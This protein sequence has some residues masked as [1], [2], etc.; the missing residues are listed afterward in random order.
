MAID[1]TNFSNIGSEL[2]SEENIQPW[3][4]EGLSEDPTINFPAPTSLPG[5]EVR[6]N[7]I[8]SP[9]FPNM[10]VIPKQHSAVDYVLTS[11]R[12]LDSD[13]K[14]NNYG[15]IYTF[16]SGPDGSSFYDRYRAFG[17]EKFAEVGFSPFRNNEA[18]FNANTT[19]WDR[20]KRML[21]HSLPTLFKRGFIDGPKSLALMISGN[22]RGADLEDAEEYE[23]AAAIGMDSTGGIGAFM[24]NTVMNFGYTAGIISEAILEEIGMTMVTGLTRGSTAGAQAARTGML[25]NRIGKG[26]GKFGSGAKAMKNLFK[27]AKSPASAQKFWKAVRSPVG[28][29]VNPL[30]NTFETIRG[31]SKASKSGADLTRLA[32][33]SKTAG[34]LY[35]DVRNINMAVSEARLEA[36]M[37]ENDVYKELNAKYMKEHDGQAPDE[38]TQKDMRLQAKK[39]GLET[40]NGNAGF[41]YL[42]NKITFGNITSPKGGLRNFL[43]ETRK[44]IFDVGNQTGK[45]G[46]L[47]RVVYDKGK[48]AFQFEK[49]NAINLAKSWWKQ[50]GYATAKKTLGYFKSNVSEGL[51]ENIQ[52]IISRAN[53]KHYVEAYGTE[54]VSAALYGRGVMAQDFAAGSTGK[55]PWDTYMEEAEKEFSTT[56]FET[57]M[58]GFMMGTLSGPLNAAYPFLSTQY[59]RMYNKDEY[60][61]WKEMKLK[62]TTDIVNRLNEISDP[63]QGNIKSMLDSHIVNMGTQDA[64]STIQRYGTK[65]EALDASDESFIKSVHTMRESNSTEVFIDMLDSMKELTDQELADAVGSIEVKDAPKYRERIDR[66]INK[67]NQIEE[68]FKDAEKRFPNPVD[69]SQAKQDA[70]TPEEFK[71]QKALHDAWNLSV[72]NYVF[73][74]QSFKDAQQ[75]MNSINQEYLKDETLSNLDY[76]AAKVL[77]DPQM[78]RQQAAILAKELEA[79]QELESQFPGEKEQKIASIKRQQKALEEFIMGYAEFDVFYN[80]DT[81]AGKIIE[82]LKSE[83]VENPTE[84]QIAKRLDEE[85]GPLSDENKQTEIISKLKAAHDEY[86]NSLAGRNISPFQ[87]DLDNAFTQL[88]DYY[89]LDQESR[90]MAEYINILHDPGAFIELVRENQKIELELQ[91][92]KDALNRKLVDAEIDKVELNALLNDLQDRNLQLEI[93]QLIDFMKNKVVPEYFVDA[94]NGSKYY[95]DTPQYKEGLRLIIQK[96]EFSKI[97]TSSIDPATGIAMTPEMQESVLAANEAFKES[98]LFEDL[99]NGQNYTKNKEPFTRVSAAIEAMVGDGGYSSVGVVLTDPNSEFNQVFNNA[100]FDAELERWVPG[101]FEFNADKI[102]EFINAVRTLANSAEQS[103]RSYGINEQTLSKIRQE[104]LTYLNNQTLASKQRRIDAL[105]E[106]L[107]TTDV[108]N[109]SLLQEEI[110]KLEQTE[111]LEINKNNLQGVINDLL[112]RVSYQVDRDRGLVLDDLLRDF[113]DPQTTEISYDENLITKEAFDSLFGPNGYLQ[114]LKQMQM[115]G[116]IYIF[117]KDLTLGDN[118]LVDANGQ[119][120][121]NIAGTL[122]LFIVDKEGTEYIVDLKTGLAEKW[123][124][125]VNPNDTKHYPKFYRNSIQQMSYANL[126]FNKSGREAKPLILPIAVQQDDTTGKILTAG[127]PPAKTFVGQESLFTTEPMFIAVDD[128]IAITKDGNVLTTDIVNSI[129]PRATQQDGTLEVD[130]D[131]N[132]VGSKKPRYQD[133]KVPVGR[134][135]FTVINST[136]GTTKTYRVT[137]YLDGSEGNFKEVLENGD[138]T[139]TKDF[140][141]LKSFKDIKEVLENNEDVSV[142]IIKEEDYKAIMNPKMFDRLTT[143]QQRRVDSQRNEFEIFDRDRMA[144]KNKAIQDIVYDKTSKGYPALITSMKLSN[145]KVRSF[146]KPLIFQDESGQYIEAS[147]DQLNT[148]KQEIIKKITDI[149]AYEKS[150]FGRDKKIAQTYDDLTGRVFSAYIGKVPNEEWTL[151]DPIEDRYTD[152]PMETEVIIESLYL[153]DDNNYVITAVNLR[154]GNEY[155]YTIDSEGGVLEKV[156][157]GKIYKTE[158]F[159]TDRIFIPEDHEVRLRTEEEMNAEV[160][161]ELP[162]GFRYLED[163]EVLPAGNYETRISVDGKRTIT[164]AP[165]AVNKINEDTVLLRDNQFISEAVLPKDI[166]GMFIYA[167][168]GSG[169]SVYISSLNDE[170]VYDADDLFVEAIQ[171]VGF[172]LKSPNEA[173]QNYI[174][175]FSFS[176]EGRATGYTKGN[177]NDVVLQNIDQILASGGTVFT[178]TLKFITEAEYVILAPANHEGVL[179]KFGSEEQIQSYKAKESDL[180]AGEIYVGKSEA[181]DDA[182]MAA[183]ISNSNDTLQLYKNLESVKD[184]LT[185]EVYSQLKEQLDDK[186]SVLLDPTGKNMI[187]TNTIVTFINDVPSQKISSGQDIKIVSIDA[188][189]SKVIVKKS[190][191]GNFKNIAMDYQDYLSALDVTSTEE[192]PEGVDDE[193]TSYVSE[194][195]SN[196]EKL[197]KL[198]KKDDDY[199]DYLDESNDEDI[200]GC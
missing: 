155:D 69:L 165:V 34:S 55:T 135:T 3:S 65:K 58:S 178:G 9:L 26:L 147:D 188:L 94:F 27:V 144:R 4:G 129:V 157:D 148:A 64:V 43:K 194:A 75:R 181:V 47:G 103:K 145:G 113:F 162:E 88:L 17:E 5:V 128:N 133:S 116:D 38:E 13:V 160:E 126:Y 154:T 54:S 117:S 93:D 138:F 136:E 59:N 151:G 19:W 149:S 193:T 90:R 36:G 199:N 84:Y 167:T 192:V 22:F 77:F 76:T 189:K 158:S 28:R 78:A 74:N 81:R 109:K 169:K 44:E 73:F 112:P 62:A 98:S 96:Q 18:N 30:E 198:D 173:V 191:P 67:I 25:L 60:Q 16:D 120:L 24:N 12:A 185:A 95:P 35:R 32:K 33:V 156:N 159:E 127:R 70:V 115:N 163:G 182:N 105:K 56:G 20:S 7:L 176:D 177:I 53:K 72:Y 140:G 82:I 80:R 46:K 146:V 101:K 180:L 83:G 61:K 51:Q 40:F 195:L 161:Q 108:N 14:R 114:P 92:E 175:D 187:T 200:F 42:T 57:F 196:T 141:K 142:E 63:K 164:N 89:K 139:N 131:G 49:N 118:N 10:D 152:V 91:Q 190:G 99:E 172:R 6:E 170:N 166:K 102:D 39:A 86:I 1:N 66:A 143:D 8:G 23:R 150:D 124:P 29:V 79:A 122:D 186:A 179:E 130:E 85:L 125:Y 123:I 41:I 132:L 11:Q 87:E 37:V 100:T 134:K 184:S 119:K 2:P 107:K 21:N 121:D 111:P 137:E 174:E 104:L 50:P 110:D 71:A 168:P 68:A 97:K 48:K 171:N 31:F 106:R 52:E 183:Q 45:F 15:Q 153:N 197:D